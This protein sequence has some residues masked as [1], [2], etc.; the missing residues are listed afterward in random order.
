MGNSASTANP[1][2]HSNAASH[3]SAVAAANQVPTPHRDAN[4]DKSIGKE[5]QRKPSASPSPDDPNHSLK[6]RKKSLELPDLALLSTTGP[7]SARGRQSKPASIPISIPVPPKPSFNDYSENL[8]KPVRQTVFIPSSDHLPTTN[9]YEAPSE[10]P[11]GSRGPRQKERVRDREK[12]LQIEREDEAQRERDR[13]RRRERREQRQQQQGGSGGTSAAPRGRQQPIRDPNAVARLQDLYEQSNQPIAERA[14]PAPVS[15]TAPAQQPRRGQGEQPEDFHRRMAAREQEQRSQQQAEVERR[16]AARRARYTP[17]VVRSSIPILLGQRGE[18]GAAAVAAAAAAESLRTMAPL[19]ASATITFGQSKTGKGKAVPKMVLTQIDENSE[20][21]TPT[22]DVTEHQEAILTSAAT[23]GVITLE[24]PNGDVLRAD[25]V[26]VTI[27]WKGGGDEVILARA[28]DNEWKGRTL[29]DR[30]SPTSNLWS[31]SIF[32]RPGTHHL[33][34]LVDGQWRVADD[35]PA[36]VDDQGSLANYVAVPFSFGTDG[37]APQI[38]PA[39]AKRIPEVIKKVIPGQSFWS[40]ESS[41]DGEDDETPRSRPLDPNA[42]QVKGPAH[43][44][45]AL[46]GYN[47]AK[48]TNV[49]PPALIEAQREEEQYLA[50]T[51]GQYETTGNHGQRVTTGFIPAPNIP[52][53][54][55]L[56]RH[57]DKLILNSK[58]GEQ[59]G[60]EG[61]ERRRERDKDSN[62]DRDRDRD[63]DMQGGV[64]SGQ[65]GRKRDKAERQRE[66]ELERA[67]RQREKERLK[68]EAER[69]QKAERLRATMQRAVPLAPPPSEYGDDDGPK[70][71]YVVHPIEESHRPLSNTPP[72]PMQPRMGLWDPRAVAAIL[73]PGTMMPPPGAIQTPGQFGMAG[74]SGYDSRSGSP[75]LYLHGQ[76][77]GMPMYAG[78]IINQGSSTP[79]AGP[80]TTPIDV[81]MPP[82]PPSGSSSNDGSGSRLITLNDD[83]MPAVTDDNSVLPVPTHV[84]LHHLCTSA[85]KNGVLAV[86]TTTRYKKKYLTTVYYKPSEPNGPL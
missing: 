10:D 35:L 78:Q 66:R 72:P 63:A 77:G 48:W 61:R 24:E 59:K 83:N 52:P 30:L 21:P 74:G 46:I 20:T 22:I 9:Q 41:A 68:A 12:E 51:N 40:A 11:Y 54:P 38:E 82:P 86:A 7:Y 73:P 69:D 33:R 71:D 47:Q 18:A 79:T 58:L 55:S 75:R 8:E 23:D 39:D 37:P 84:V 42:Q 60:K 31:L 16:Q 6:T 32:L 14:A 43:A 81:T 34:F 65:A 5:P 70:E 49:I 50:A 85:I 44:N 26:E 57:L 67:E 36:A 56:P 3:L 2:T 19:T 4:K 62:R 15:S 1:K 76:T 27:I 80:A 17:E 64:G 13:D 53:A 45:P 25:P 28:G 29:M